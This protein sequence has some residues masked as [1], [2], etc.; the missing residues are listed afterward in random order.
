MATDT[1][2]LPA[3][4]RAVLLRTPGG[5]ESLTVE[6]LPLPE[7]RD[8]DALVR[9]HA[10]AITRDELTW[11]VDR[12]PAIPSYEMSGVVVALS[13]TTGG[14]SIG[15]EVFALTSFDRNGAAADYVAVAAEALSPRPTTLDHIE[16]A[17]I[18]LAA[19]SAWQGLVTHGGLERGQRVVVHGATGG[20]GH[21]AVQLA[22]SRG[23]YVIAT[24]S[25]RGLEGAQRLDV[26]ELV[27][28]SRFDALE[29]VDLVFDTVGGELLARSPAVL[30]AGGRI[31]TVA[32]E[33]PEGVDAVY[34]IVEP[35]HGQLMELARLTDAGELKPE[36]DSVFSLDDARSAFERSA[37]RGKHGKVVFRVVDE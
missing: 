27:E 18:P 7:L 28:A 2:A 26:D 32:E 24:A 6:Q 34:F 35:D 25:P 30:R 8:G 11:P 10:A 15:D 29:G 16:S 4:M 19:L 37:A 17:T 21:L 20:V 3:T 9:V 31:V 12:L 5:P 14:I 1:R 36:I 33:P 23:A 13:A 22:R